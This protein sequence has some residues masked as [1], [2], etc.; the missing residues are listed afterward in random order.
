M[1]QNI[2]QEIFKV[3]DNAKGTAEYWRSYQLVVDT[4]GIA[5]GFLRCRFCNRIDTYDSYKGCRPLKAHAVDCNAL[6]KTTSIRSYIKKE[7][8]ITKEEKTAL[9]LSALEFCYKDIRPFLS[10]EGEGL[11]SLLL[12]VSKLSS[13]YGSFSEEQMKKFLP[14]SNT[15]SKLIC[16]C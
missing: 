12:S 15:V 5:T 13:K 1:E 7:I 14:C 8:S 9:S 11:R 3:I 16:L 2:K 4:K 10:I 6:S